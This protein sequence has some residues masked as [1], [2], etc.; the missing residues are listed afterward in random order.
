M[1]QFYEREEGEVTDDDEEDLPSTT[2]TGNNL[3]PNIDPSSLDDLRLAVFRSVVQR[4]LRTVDK[5]SS[6]AIKSILPSIIIRETDDKDNGSSSDMEV[7]TWVPSEPIKEKPAM[8]EISYESVI[9][10]SSMGSS[11]C[12]EVTAPNVLSTVSTTATDESTT[13][14]ATDDTDT[15]A[16]A[17]RRDFSVVFH[18]V[19]GEELDTFGLGI[20]QQKSRRTKLTNPDAAANLSESQRLG[21]SFTYF[22]EVKTIASDAPLVDTSIADALRAKL[23]GDREAR[24]NK[25]QTNNG[26]EDRLLA[27]TD[28]SRVISATATSSRAATFS[29]AV[30]ADKS[31]VHG[32]S[33]IVKVE[34]LD[35]STPPA[36]VSKIATA[37]PIQSIGVVQ[38]RTNM[39]E[40]IA[41][42]KLQ[43]LLREKAAAK[44]KDA[45]LTALASG[46]KNCSVASTPHQPCA[47]MPQKRADFSPVPAS[48][49]S[50]SIISPLIPFTAP[51]SS[52]VSV[53]AALFPSHTTVHYSHSM[54]PLSLS[55]APPFY[56]PLPRQPS[57]PVPPVPPT[58]CPPPLSEQDL[59]AAALTSRK[60][61]SRDDVETPVVNKA[62]GKRPHPASNPPTPTTSAPATAV[63]RP[64]T[65][66]VYP[67]SRTGLGPSPSPSPF[68]FL[69]LPPPYHRPVLIFGDMGTHNSDSPSNVQ[70]PHSEGVQAPTERRSS[71]FGKSWRYVPTVA[72][73]EESQ[74]IA[75]TITLPPTA[76]K[77]HSRS[78]SSKKKSSLSQPSQNQNQGYSHSQDQGQGSTTLFSALMQI[79]A[80]FRQGIG[81]A[82]SFKHESHKQTPKRP[83]A[84]TPSTIKINT[85]LEEGEVDSEEEDREEGEWLCASQ[86]DSNDVTIDVPMNCSEYTAPGQSA[87]EHVEVGKVSHGRAVE[88]NEDDR[89]HGSEP[90]LSASRMRSGSLSIGL[91]SG[92]R[93][94]GPSQSCTAEINGSKILLSSSSS[95]S[96]TSSLCYVEKETPFNISD[97]DELFPANEID[98]EDENENGVKTSDSSDSFSPREHI[99]VSPKLATKSFTRRM[100]L[101]R[102]WNQDRE[103]EKKK[104]GGKEKEKES[105]GEKEKERLTD[106]S[107]TETESVSTLTNC[108]VS[109]RDITAASIDKPIELV[110]DG[111][112]TSPEVCIAL[113]PADEVK[114]PDMLGDTTVCIDEVASPTH[115]D[116]QTATHTKASNT[117]MQIINDGQTVHLDK[118]EL[119]SLQCNRHLV[120]HTISMSSSSTA[121]CDTSDIPITSSI[122]SGEGCTVEECVEGEHLSVVTDS[123]TDVSEKAIQE[124]ET[125]LSTAAAASSSS[126]LTVKASPAMPSLLQLQERESLRR[127]EAELKVITIHMNSKIQ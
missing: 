92:D 109:V 41:R 8:T 46:Q 62:A 67:S 10:L 11:A 20:K 60:K 15:H 127:R 86:T 2:Q 106:L 51:S 115:T 125:S 65:P 4:K 100:E 12:K 85:E 14:V 49:L 72:S 89:R 36:P 37:L 19:K 90:S 116:A 69:P 53:S 34:N 22:R 74:F 31:R 108:P 47:V 70:E 124:N 45:V 57:P 56:P 96:S 39:E 123:T 102:K 110:G 27:N 29:S 43:I 25:E 101:L 81:Q 38:Q 16:V 75:P 83:L 88:R 55:S 113:S 121:D 24:K 93:S 79:G 30:H 91:N 73:R 66:S 97:P 23:L 50:H 104:E 120:S 68:P 64:P 1:V 58:D 94:V 40:S 48:K 17:S 32:G 21:A 114:T 111:D 61:R 18:F 5:R 13:I 95:S 71:G 63:S 126:S 9:K 80:G 3:D 6:Q 118:G 76:T 33:I 112:V 117:D 87:T 105:E 7:E 122:H 107:N 42:L 44:K 119:S 28:P 98:I 59:R 77:N 99:Q 82:K 26:S 52:S 35:K 78:R 103:E 54:G 84:A